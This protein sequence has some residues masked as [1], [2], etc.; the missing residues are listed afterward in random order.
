MA[1]DVA[2]DITVMH[3][4]YGNPDLSTGVNGYWRD[5]WELAGSTWTEVFPTTPAPYRQNHSLA[6]DPVRHR[7]VLYGGSGPVAGLSELFD[8][9]WEYDGTTWSQIATAHAPPPRQGAT[10]TF[11]PRLGRIVLFGGSDSNDVMGDTWTYD[12]SDWIQLALT[13][14]PGGRS[15]HTMVFDQARGSLLVFGGHDT[16]AIELHDV[17]ELTGSTWRE[18]LPIPS[19]PLP[20]IRDRHVMTYDAAHRQVVLW[21]GISATLAQR[22][23]WTFS[24]ASTAPR[25][26]CTGGADYDG[27]LKIGCAD[28]DCVGACTKCGDGTC[29]PVESCRSCPVDCPVNTTACPLR[30]GDLYCDAGENLGTCPGDCTP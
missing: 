4:G 5:T 2:R 1:Y 3:G 22:D 12:G 13:E 24:F 19:L 15:E 8:H 16:T 10:M 17:W 30:C 28:D 27:D 25:E 14:S 26:V 20:S 23:T 11:D 21:G 6:Y 18:I 7:V 29:Q 9:T